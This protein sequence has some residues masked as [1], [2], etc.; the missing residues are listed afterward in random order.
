MVL[1]DEN[2][3][4]DD[5]YQFK[6][7]LKDLKLVSDAVREKGFS[8]SSATLEYIPT[9]LVSLSHEPYQKASKLLDLLSDHNDVMEVYAN[10][11]LESQ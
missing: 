2:E 1:D 4:S 10:Y 3:D 7:H 6:C 9:L 11:V 5:C 8:V